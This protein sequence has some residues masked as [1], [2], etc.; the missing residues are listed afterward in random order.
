M[1]SN[2]RGSQD[3]QFWRPGASPKRPEGPVCNQG[4][5]LKFRPLSIHF[6]YER[7]KVWPRRSISLVPQKQRLPHPCILR[8]GGNDPTR[9]KPP[10]GVKK[11]PAT[12]SA[13]TTASPKGSLKI[14]RRF[15]A[16]SRHKKRIAS[17]RDA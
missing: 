3:K 12:A 6:T 9:R 17:H 10:L 7:L 1:L 2:P 11:I 16:G 4:L 14:A 15:S 13:Q 5:A 8:N